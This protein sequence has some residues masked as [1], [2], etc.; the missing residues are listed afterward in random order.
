[1]PQ[2]G[3]ETTDAMEAQTASRPVGRAHGIQGLL[4]QARKA[5]IRLGKLE[6]A[7][8]KTAKQWQAFQQGL[9]DSFI[10]EQARFQK[11]SAQLEQEIQ[12][13][14]QEQEK[15]YQVVRQAFLG[16]MPGSMQVDQEEGVAEEQW[17]RM[18][19]SWEQED[20]AYLRDIIGRRPT[21]AVPAPPAE[22]MLSPEIQQ[23]LAF[24]SAQNFPL[25][26]VPPAHMA[27]PGT[28]PGMSPPGLTMTMPCGQAPATAPPAP[29]PGPPTTP[30]PMG[31]VQAENAVDPSGHPAMTSATDD[32]ATADGG[33]G[34]A[35]G[36]AR[37]AL[38][39]SGLPKRHCVKTHT[40]PVSPLSGRPALAEKLANRREAA[41]AQLHAEVPGGASMP[42]SFSPGMDPS[43]PTGLVPEEATG[44]TAT[45]QLEQQ[46]QGRPPEFSGAPPRFAIYD[47][48][49]TDSDLEA[50]ANEE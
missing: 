47:D 24:F 2:G 13:A 29:A 33:T 16:G 15:A 31:P 50:R 12:E 18:R 39:S 26:G 6:K 28:G 10:K 14:T 45:G 36:K 37:R 22:R 21:P 5:E 27:A 8:A 7:K 44:P 1:M 25:G 40:K 34:P 9:K 35:G 19:A 23:L 41:L 32:G 3:V 49:D 43:N 30:A 11:H 4:N 48:D 42:V 17:S 46:G 20:D 38:S